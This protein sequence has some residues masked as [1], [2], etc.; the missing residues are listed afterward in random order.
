MM[1]E[2]KIG[3]KVWRWQEQEASHK[4]FDWGSIP[5]TATL[6]H[7]LLYAIINYDYMSGL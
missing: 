1:R 4:G 7:N 2:W 5:L 6:H 3:L